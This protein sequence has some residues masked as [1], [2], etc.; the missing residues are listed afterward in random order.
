[1]G[2]SKLL[3]IVLVTPFLFVA[4]DSLLREIKALVARHSSKLSVSGSPVL[5]QLCLASL[6]CFQQPFI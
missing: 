6:I 2:M 5:G 1:M 4:S 3:D